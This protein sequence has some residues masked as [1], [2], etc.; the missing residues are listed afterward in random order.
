MV[1]MLRRNYIRKHSCH[2]RLLTF[3]IASVSATKDSFGESCYFIEC[4]SL[5][6]EIHPLESQKWWQQIFL[7][8]VP[9]RSEIIGPLGLT[10]LFCPICQYRKNTVDVDRQVLFSSSLRCTPELFFSRAWHATCLSTW[11]F[12]LKG[13]PSEHSSV[14]QL[15]F[16]RF[17]FSWLTV[18]PGVPRNLFFF[19][20]SFYYICFE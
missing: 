2:V 9:G 17:F 7:S 14:W 4:G 8:L 15:S 5:L 3:L 16:L 18:S 1:L 6:R 10:A 20:W 13:I 19:F 12:S 11:P